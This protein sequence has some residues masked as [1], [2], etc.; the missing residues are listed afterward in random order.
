MTWDEILVAA[1]GLLAFDVGAT[2]SG[3]RDPDLRRRVGEALRNMDDADF[4]RRLVD[5]ILAGST[6]P[7]TVED[8]VEMV[9]WLVEARWATP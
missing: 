6:H 4:Y 1:D 8:H 2:D 3:V 7:M 9:R 5:I